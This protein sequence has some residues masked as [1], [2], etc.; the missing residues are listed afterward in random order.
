MSTPETI[1]LTKHQ[2]GVP[3]ALL[4]QLQAT[5]A[6]MCLHYCLN[7]NTMNTPELQK[8]MYNMYHGNTDLNIVSQVDL[9]YNG[10]TNYAA[11]YH[12]KESVNLD[13]N[14]EPAKSQEVNSKKALISALNGYEDSIK[15]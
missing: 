4:K 5:A 9:L 10:K 8:R 2:K 11:L 12:E 6:I 7:L 13:K 3:A 14:A 1:V 15:Y